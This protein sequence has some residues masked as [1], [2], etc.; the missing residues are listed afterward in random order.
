MTDDKITAIVGWPTEPEMAKY[1]AVA[2]AA[3]AA[4]R[5]R[6]AKLCEGMDFGETPE[7]YAWTIRTDWASDDDEPD[8]SEQGGT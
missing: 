3:E 4:E 7:N 2:A 5:E 1:R 6:C 8:T